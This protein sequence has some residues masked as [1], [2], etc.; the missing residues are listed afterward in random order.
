MKRD[1]TVQP[2]V[3]GSLDHEFSGGDDVHINTTDETVRE[4]GNIYIPL[5]HGRKRFKVVNASR[6]H[7]DCYLKG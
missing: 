3:G 2:N 6:G 1:E 5:N 7:N 4:G